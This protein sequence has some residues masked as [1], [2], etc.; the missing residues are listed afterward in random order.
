MNHIKNSLAAGITALGIAYSGA[1][2]AQEL[3]EMDEEVFNAC[4][5][6]AVIRAAD[7]PL[8]MNENLMVEG[9]NFVDLNGTRLTLNKDM[10]VSGSGKHADDAVRAFVACY[11]DPN[12]TL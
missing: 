6:D 5:V 7:A 8:E 4:A 3:P 11:S 12:L 10:S 2:A 1:A 9:P